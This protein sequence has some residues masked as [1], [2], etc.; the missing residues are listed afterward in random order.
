MGVSIYLQETTFACILIIA[1]IR[2]NVKFQGLQATGSCAFHSDSGN[3]ATELLLQ[4][5]ERI[6][7]LAAAAIASDPSAT[8]HISVHYLIYMKP[9]P[10]HE[11]FR[12]RH[13]LV[14]LWN[15]FDSGL[16]NIQRIPPSP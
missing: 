3:F 9:W 16:P 1:T 8:S 6:A 13:H 10:F 2:Y 15:P 5:F 14:L 4:M 11:M 7:I 12:Q